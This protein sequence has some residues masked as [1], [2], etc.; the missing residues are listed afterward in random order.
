MSFG[1]YIKDLRVYS[2]LSQRELAIK[3]GI[4]NAEISRIEKSLRRRPSPLVLNALAPHLKVSYEE[5]MHKAGY[6]KEPVFNQNYIESIFLDEEG[7]VIDVSRRAQE[8]YKRDRK[9]A[10]LAYKVSSSDIS[11]TE[12]EIIRAQTECLLEQFLKNKSK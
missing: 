3:S 5:L 10:T 9:W 12:L 8:M 11:E 6:I 2:G 7:Y 4:S 1:E